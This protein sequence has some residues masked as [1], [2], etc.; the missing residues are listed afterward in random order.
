M[1]THAYTASHAHCPFTY[2]SDPTT[3]PNV[4]LS[5]VAQLVL[6]EE[7]PNVPPRGYFLTKIYHPN[8]RYDDMY[9]TTYEI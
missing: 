3:N 2:P 7:Y 5:G 8:V 6:S 1:P 9:D 4:C